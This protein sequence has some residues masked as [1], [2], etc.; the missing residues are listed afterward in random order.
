LLDKEARA[1]KL[2]NELVGLAKR[3]V[4]DLVIRLNEAHLLD[5]PIEIA[6]SYDGIDLLVELR[7]RGRAPDFGTPAPGHERMHEE[8]AITAG[9]KSFAAGPPA[10]RASVSTQADEVRI[11]LWF[12]A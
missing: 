9:L 7:Y 11:K 3:A 2:G 1:W 6:A 5:A 12:S 8:A 10:D 4:A